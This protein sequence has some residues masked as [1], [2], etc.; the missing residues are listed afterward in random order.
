MW[1]HGLPRRVVSDSV[2]DMV[3]LKFQVPAIDRGIEDADEGRTVALEEARE[4]AASGRLR[5]APPK[6]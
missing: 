4:M 3:D 1:D 5:A 2:E 6:E